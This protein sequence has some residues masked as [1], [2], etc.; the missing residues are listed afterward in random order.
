[1]TSSV[2]QG[3]VLGPLLFILYT[4][5]MWKDLEKKII[6]YADDT[7]LYAEVASPFDRKNVT[8]SLNRDLTKIQSLYST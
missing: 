4:A 3:S 7:S 6:S 8:N 5:D 1:M 2:S